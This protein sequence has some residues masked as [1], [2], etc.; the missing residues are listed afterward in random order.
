MRKDNKGLSLVEL[1][2]A[3]A[4]TAI[5]SGSITFLIRT[6]LHLYGN[7]TTDVALQQE[8]Q[9]TLNQIMD[10]AMESQGL[11]ISGSNTETD[12]VVFGT[13]IPKVSETEPAKLDSQIIWR[14]GD[15]LYLKKELIENIE[16]ETKDETLTTTVNGKISAADASK[17][18]YLLAEYVTSFCVSAGGPIA[19]TT[20]YLNPL[21]V[22]I[23]LK[24]TKKGSG[25][26]IEKKVSDKAVLRNRVKLPIYVIDTWYSLKKETSKLEKITETVN[27]EEAAFG[28]IHY[29]GGGSSAKKTKLTV[30][31]IIPKPSTSLL[32]YLVGGKEPIDS[33]GLDACVNKYV[34][35]MQYVDPQYPDGNASINSNSQLLTNNNSGTATIP[36]YYVGGGTY[37][38]YFEKVSFNDGSVRR[39]RGGVYALNKDLGDITGFENISFISEYT[40]YDTSK[41]SKG[42]FCWVWREKDDIPK[43][44]YSYN[45]N[46]DVVTEF[47]E[48]NTIQSEISNAPVGAKVYLYDCRK[49]KI[50][51]N[52]MFI[53]YCM[54]YDMTDGRYGLCQGM[55]AQPDYNFQNNLEIRKL[56]KD[57]I[58]FLAYTPAELA[59]HDADLQRA[60]IV[61][62]LAGS[63]GIYNQA[64]NLLKV[65]EPEKIDS[66]PYGYTS[67]ITFE[68]MKYIYNKVVNYKLGIV[69]SRPTYNSVKGKTQFKNLNNLFYMLYGMENTNI[70]VDG[71]RVYGTD[72]NRYYIKDEQKVN[73]LKA[74][75]GSQAY[76]WSGRMMFTDFFKSN[77]RDQTAYSY[78]KQV[79]EKK[80]SKSKAAWYNAP[81]DYLTTV[82]FIHYR[83]TSCATVE[84]RC[85]APTPTSKETGDIGDLTIGPCYVYDTDS[86]RRS[87]YSNKFTQWK[88]QVFGDSNNFNK[89]TDKNGQRI[90][91]FLIEDYYKSSQGFR[92]V[93]NETVTGVFV[94]QAMIEDDGFVVQ[95]NPYSTTG[96]LGWLG[97]VI[98]AT[99]GVMA[100][101]SHD[102]ESIGTIELVG[103]SVGK[104]V[105]AGSPDRDDGKYD[106]P[107]NPANMTYEECVAAGMRYQHEF[108][109]LANNKG[110]GLYLTH[111][112]LEQAK[113]Y[114]NGV[115]IYMI[116]RSS[117][118]LYPTLTNNNIYNPYVYYDI[119]QDVNLSNPPAAPR[120]SEIY[121][122]Y[123]GEATRYKGGTGEKDR[124]VTEF[125]AHIP[126]NYFKGYDGEFIPPTNYG[127]N[128]MIARIGISEGEVIPFLVFD[129]TKE[130][131]GSEVFYIAVRDMFDLD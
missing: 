105:Y 48:P 21:S 62:F 15:K 72:N 111:E 74:E 6:S 89:I 120:P 11:V 7:E 25:H 65:E 2:V 55:T 43:Q 118:N 67:D 106:T 119:H 16:K 102:E 46:D 76:L 60:D 28:D 36:N 34:G 54:G 99:N 98:S 100:N 82:D 66:Q 63:S 122:E 83:E 52:E 125:R 30:V 130:L 37:N 17:E 41:Y 81:F 109:D 91:D 73:A 56:N 103:Y 64:A 10:Y 85:P 20:E 8:L 42:D 92:P 19:G 87:W 18:N 101:T 53:L 129:K 69:V 123:E 75:K 59:S 124:Y 116:V 70:V 38:G 45:G 49:N 58:E 131:A 90:L 78:E 3:I 50:V 51:N 68:E 39:G 22:D 61:F 113:E 79:V 110:K 14:D 29:V 26:D 40:S 95:Y 121:T 107:A 71:D 32:G 114:D 13:I 104:N 96:S 57:N 9:V 93:S 44:G 23:S 128:R 47:K 33:D 5:V 117:E 94:N 1:L 31:E 115:F 112:E 126:A 80:F 127:N 27:L 4:I 24:F 108:E 77:F 86:G 84:P 12:F 97:G 88:D 35:H